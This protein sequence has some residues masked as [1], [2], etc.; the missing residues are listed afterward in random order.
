MRNPYISNALN[1]QGTESLDPTPPAGDDSSMENL[2]LDSPIVRIGVR[3]PQV[4]LQIS[5]G[6][7][8]SAE[9]TLRE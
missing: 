2:N 6:E 7:A 9:R 3:A 4:A 8:H 5:P 1:P